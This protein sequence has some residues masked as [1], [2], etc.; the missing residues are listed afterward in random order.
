MTIPA[1][2][3]G[4]GASDA[5]AEGTRES[6]PPAGEDHSGPF[7]AQLQSGFEGRI[8]A[9]DAHHP[10][11]GRRQRL[12][13]NPLQS[14]GQSEKSQEF[15]LFFA[16]LFNNHFHLCRGKERGNKKEI[17]N[18]R[19]LGNKSRILLPSDRCYLLGQVVLFILIHL[20]LIEMR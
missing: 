6:E 12:A 19:W 3:N 20:T 16:S 18:V 15:S 13:Q 9:P 7:A 8:R 1:P 5:A 2:G 17:E 14:I 4:T 10:E 11:A